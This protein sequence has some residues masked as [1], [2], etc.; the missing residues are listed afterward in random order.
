VIEERNK[1]SI[2][3]LQHNFILLVPESPWY[4]SRLVGEF[5]N[6]QSYHLLEFIGHGCEI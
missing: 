5:F 6:H 1:Y 4:F 3:Q 2:Q